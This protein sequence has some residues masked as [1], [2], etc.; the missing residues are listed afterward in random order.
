MN[1]RSPTE[2]K[3]ELSKEAK[4]LRTKELKEKISDPLQLPSADEVEEFVLLMTE[5]SS[6]ELFTFCRNLEHALFEIYTKE[7]IEDLAN[8]LIGRAEDLKATWDKPITILE[9]GA[10]GGRLSHFLKQ[11]LAE[12]EVSNINI[13]A[14]DDNSW[15]IP[16]TFAV[17]KIDYA[18]ALEEY[19]PQ[20]IIT[21]WMPLYEDW[22]EA[23]RQHDSVDE[24]VLIGPAQSCCGSEETWAVL[25]GTDYN[26]KPIPESFK[27]GFRGDQLRRVERK[28]FCRD[29]ESSYSSE[30]GIH[31]VQRSNTIS[32]KREKDELN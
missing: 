6:T 32:F 22:T 23:Y 24:Y 4:A 12:L 17:S 25:T 16:S 29:D 31:V 13:I 10:G 18:S 9:T 27:N 5:G 20:I 3:P 26:G 28:Q 19:N 8:Y 2:A 14:T 30:Q 15:K 1:D 21:S 7:Y 11:R